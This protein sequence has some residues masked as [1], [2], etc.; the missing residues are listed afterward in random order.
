MFMAL[1]MKINAR[2]SGDTKTKKNAVGHET[3]RDTG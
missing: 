2:M 3:P 1:E